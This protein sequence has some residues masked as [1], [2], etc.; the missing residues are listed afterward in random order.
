MNSAAQ[1]VVGLD[2]GTGGA[3]AAA[4]DP[5]LRTWGSAAVEYPMASPQPGRAE[6]DPDEVADAALDA[7]AGTVD[8][9]RAAGARV[10]A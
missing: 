8:Q 9:A 2:L 7:L 4:Y 10:S 5:A 1:V 3:K 6:Q